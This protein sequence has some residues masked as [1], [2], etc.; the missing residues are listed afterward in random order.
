MAL[1]NSMEIDEKIFPRRSR[2]PSSVNS[3]CFHR[4]FSPCQFSVDS[5]A[6][7]TSQPALTHDRF[8]PRSLFSSQPNNRRRNV[9]RGPAHLI[10]HQHFRK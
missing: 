5:L 7:E 1:H 10:L 6:N 4:R 2:W 9:E 3:S 8:Y